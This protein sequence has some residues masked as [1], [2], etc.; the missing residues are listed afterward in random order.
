M[1][2]ARPALVR[3]RH[4]KRLEQRER[5]GVGLGR[6][7]DRHVEAAHLVDRVVVDLGEDDLLAHADRVVAATIERARVEAAEVADTRDRDRGEAIEELPHA[8]AAQRD[9]HADGHAIADLEGGDRL[10]GHT[11]VGLLAGDC[12]E[13][14]L[15]V[16]EQLGVGLRLADAHVQGDLLEA[17]GLHHARVLEALDELRLDLCEVALLEAR[18]DLGLGD[19]H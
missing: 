19:W 14:L 5:L 17:R 4:P 13:L 8:R 12:G 15:G 9:G 11:H 2:L 18:V 1:V 7:G 16:V 10:A 3:E 6:R